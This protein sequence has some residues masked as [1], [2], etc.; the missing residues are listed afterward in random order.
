M[1]RIVVTGFRPL[2]VHGARILRRAL[3]SWRRIEWRRSYTGREFY[4][5]PRRRR[6]YRPRPKERHRG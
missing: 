5:R 1:T 6:D 2:T 3:I 4:A